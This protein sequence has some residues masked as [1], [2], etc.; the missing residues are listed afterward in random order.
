MNISSHEKYL[1]DI[2][3]DNGKI[4]KT[5]EDRVA[6]GY[7]KVS[8]ILAILSEV[9]LGKHRVEMGLHLRQAM[10]INGVLFNSDAWHGVTKTD[11]EKFEIIDNFL[12]KSIVKAHSK[13]TTVFTHLETGTLPI[14]FIIA[15][16]RLNYLHNILKR[17]KSEMLLNVF[18]AQQE[19]PLKGDFIKLIEDDLN[20]LNEVYDENKFKS[21]SKNM[22]KKYIKNKIRD[23][24]FKYLKNEQEQKSKVKN[25]KYTKFKIQK[26]LKSGLFS[27]YEVEILFK[28]RSRNID[29]K[30]NFK[31]KYEKEINQNLQCRMK[32]CTE[33]ED[34]PHILKC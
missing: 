29:V 19:K 4:D 34:Q 17:N 6:K 33:I 12:L 10:F 20:Y 24:A 32:N 28:L 8:E 18:K 7:G 13:T 3:Q 26:Y 9:P 22:F 23:A 5:I 15:S 31:T 25:I 14:S 30:S 2:L 27:N 11:I 16:R 1:G 21:M